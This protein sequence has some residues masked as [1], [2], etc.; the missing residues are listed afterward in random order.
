MQILCFGPECTVWCTEV[1]E[2]V[3]HQ[4]HPFYFIG[5]KMKFGCVLEHL[6]AKLLFRAWMYYLGVLKLRKWFRT[7]CIHSTPLDDVW[8][9]FWAFRKPSA[10]K[11]MLNFCFGTVCTILLY[12]SCENGFAPNA[13]ILLHWSL[14]DVWLSLEAFKKPSACKKMQNLCLRHECPNL[15]YRSCENVFTLYASILLH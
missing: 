6:D 8:L 13:S 9:Y 10:S 4:M 14:N 2:M 12:R 5:P 15:E 7:K 1:V 3:S 11:K